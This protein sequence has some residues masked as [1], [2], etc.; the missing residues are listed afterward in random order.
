MAGVDLAY[1]TG[2]V[3]EVEILGVQVVVLYPYLGLGLKSSE[4]YVPRNG[5]SAQ[6]MCGK[7]PASA[8]RHTGV[9]IARILAR[10][11][12]GGNYSTDIILC[13]GMVS[14][15]LLSVGC[16]HAAE[17]TSLLKNLK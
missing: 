13:L 14:G 3:V 12:Y 7:H 1:G 4:Y 11:V 10:I 9:W 15:N 8:P 6:D 5:L 17:W 16:I 2:C